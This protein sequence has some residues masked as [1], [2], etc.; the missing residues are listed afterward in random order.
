MLI[1]R[2]IFK[3]LRIISSESAKIFALFFFFLTTD[4]YKTLQTPDFTGST[5]FKKIIQIKAHSL[6]NLFSESFGEVLKTYGNFNSKGS[7][8]HPFD[9]H[10]GIHDLLCGVD[11]QRRF[12]YISR[13]QSNL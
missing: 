3:R 10:S 13:R 12:G 2:E 4:F 5:R 7:E 9:E 1:F 11:A 6:R 8:P